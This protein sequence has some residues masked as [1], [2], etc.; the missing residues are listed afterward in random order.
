MSLKRDAF[1]GI[2]ETALAPGGDSKVFCEKNYL[3]AM[4]VCFSF[5]LGDGA[6]AIDIFKMWDKI[7]LINS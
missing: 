5:F 6:D 1:C 4:F 3:I 7:S 2:G